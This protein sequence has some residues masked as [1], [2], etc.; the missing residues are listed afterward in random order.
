MNTAIALLEAEVLALN[1]ADRTRL[2]ERLMGRFDK[3]SPHILGI[4]HILLAITPDGEAA[5]RWFYGEVL[6]LTEIPKPQVL[7]GRGGLWFEC[8]PLQIHLGVETDFQASKKAHPA[9]L[10]TSLA[11]FLARL[12]AAN[13]IIEQDRQLP[14]FERAFTI[15]PFGNRIELMQPI[16]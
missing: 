16:N 8:G 11:W 10:V 12:Q 15:D 6:G 5:A 9:L 7:A 3:T 2:L 13:C 1:K 14:G 4:N